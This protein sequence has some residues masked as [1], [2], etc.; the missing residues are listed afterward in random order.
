MMRRRLG[1]LAVL[2]VSGCSSLSERAF[3]RPVVAVRGVR[4]H[5]VGLTGGSIDVS[6]FINNPNP[7]PLPVQRATYRFALADS[8]EIGRGETATP[9]TVPAHDSAVVQLPVN[10]SWPGLRAAARDEDRACF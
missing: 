5:S 1:V 6:L 8:T 2:L 4:V 10:V 9:F 7:Y 3:S